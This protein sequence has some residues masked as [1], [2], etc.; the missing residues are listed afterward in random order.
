MYGA[1]YQKGKAVHHNGLEHN[2]VDIK[3]VIM[4]HIYIVDASTAVVRGGFKY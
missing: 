3:K 1:V 2:I 4:P